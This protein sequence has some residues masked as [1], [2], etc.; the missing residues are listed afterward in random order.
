MA[1]NVLV[2]CSDQHWRDAA[3]CYGHPLVLTP[4][5]DTLARRGTIFD[6]AYSAAPICVSAR[7]A[8]QT[9]RWESWLQ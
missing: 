8:M 5:I 2:I 1:S 3:G 6:V 9:G 4:N 7:A